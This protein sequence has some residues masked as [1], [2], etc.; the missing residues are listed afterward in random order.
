ME[1]DITVGS[2]V[3]FIVQNRQVHVGTAQN[4]VHLLLHAHD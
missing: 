3:E 2:A 1:A 4:Y